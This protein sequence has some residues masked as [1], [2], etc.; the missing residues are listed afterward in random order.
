MIPIN[1]TEENISAL[2]AAFG[3]QVASMPFTYLGYFLILFWSSSDDYLGAF[4][5]C[6]LCYVFTQASYWCN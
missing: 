6:D 5:Y 4:S 2:A 1:V 3:C